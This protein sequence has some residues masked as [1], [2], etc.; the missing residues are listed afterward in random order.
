MT[1]TNKRNIDF[2][3]KYEKEKFIIPGIIYIIGV[4]ISYYGSKG[5]EEI[6]VLGA[7]GYVITTSA[8]IILFRNWIN[9]KYRLGLEIGFPLNK[10]FPNYPLVEDYDELTSN[11]SKFKKAY[12]DFLNRKDRNRD[13]STL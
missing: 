3:R 4:V 5:T 2:N 9:E 10:I 12:G 8:L 6:T 7:I 13:N 1:G 11:M